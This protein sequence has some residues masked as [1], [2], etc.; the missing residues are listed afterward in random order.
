[1]KYKLFFEKYFP[2]HKKY[3][4]YTQTKP[5]IPFR[6]HISFPCGTCRKYPV[7]VVLVNF[8]GTAAAYPMWVVT[9]RIDKCDDSLFIC[10][11]NMAMLSWH[12]E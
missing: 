11:G 9:N 4:Y 6:L 7:F 3:V 12:L 1:M 10:M 8:R 5:K 2:F